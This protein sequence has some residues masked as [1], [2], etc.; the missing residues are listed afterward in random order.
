MPSV[1]KATE[2]EEKS[3]K[4]FESFVGGEQPRFQVA[5][6]EGGSLMNLFKGSGG[7]KKWEQV[8]EI[9]LGLLKWVEDN[10]DTAK[11]GDFRAKMMN[12]SKSLRAVNSKLQL[13]EFCLT[14]F[15][16]LMVLSGVARSG[17]K[18]L[19]QSYPVKQRGSD[20]M[21]Q[22]CGVVRSEIEIAL[23][24]LAEELGLDVKRLGII[25]N[26]CCEMSPNRK[27][28]HDYMFKDQ[29]LFMLRLDK[30]GVCRPHVKRCG[31]CDWRPVRCGLDEDDDVEIMNRLEGVNL[32]N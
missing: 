27:D 18:T 32:N 24:G 1:E 3:D 28:I 12:T 14:L 7:D 25:E 22:H 15:V 13:G 30:D 21:L 10:G 9:L 17:W 23:R 6:L 29:D 26:V 2:Y 8:I 11:M 5:P 4:F 19:D 16:Q 20:K 31:Q